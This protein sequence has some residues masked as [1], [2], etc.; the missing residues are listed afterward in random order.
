MKNRFDAQ[1]LQ[2][3]HFKCENKSD[4]PV[5]IVKDYEFDLC[6]GCNREMWLDGQYYRI[7]KGC[8]VIR[9]PGQSVHTKGVYDCYM[10]TLDFSFRS[11]PYI[12]SRNTSTHIQKPFDSEIWEILP[13][14]FKPEHYGDYIRIFKSLFSINEMN[15][16]DDPKTPMLINRLLHLLLSDSFSLLASAD[17][18]PQTPIDEVSI[19][20]KNHFMEEIN[21]DLLSSVVNLNKNY[22]V[23]QFKKSFGVSPISYLINIRMN[24]AKKLLTET[25]LPIKIIAYNCGYNDPAFFNSYFKKIYSVTPVE[26]RLLQQN[27]GN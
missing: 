17:N 12:Y 20:I 4:S 10:L 3:M 24:H 8:F 7:E 21:L 26:Y 9:R 18:T 19:Y 11:L 15:I 1:V 22:I 13:S 6:V 5:R 16:N 14:V 27:I 25:D 23:R 2:C